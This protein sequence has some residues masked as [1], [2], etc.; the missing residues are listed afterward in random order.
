[1]SALL[2]STLA[3]VSEGDVITASNF[4]AERQ[5][6]NGWQEIALISP[7]YNNYHNSN[8]GQSFVAEIS[9]QLT[10]V[11]TLLAAGLGSRIA[12]SPPLSVSIY[13]S[14]DSLPAQKLGSVTFSAT[15][16]PAVFDT[17]DHRVAVDFSSQGIALVANR[18]YIVTYETPF[19]I[20]S[21]DRIVAPYY[22]GLVLENPIPFGRVTSLARDGVHWEKS[23]APTPPY[24]FELATRVWVV[25]E[26]ATSALV[27]VSL[28]LS[29]LPGFRLR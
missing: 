28:I 29:A 25:P 21:G 23:P 1:L 4:P 9:G 11:D 26:P 7:T 14:M 12:G 19:G 15:S 27:V 6:T 18:E 10:R 3:A 5:S 2:V 13:R 20:S 22:V 24:T 17:N 8:W 16:F